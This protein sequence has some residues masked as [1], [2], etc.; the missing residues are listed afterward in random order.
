M[1]RGAILALGLAAGVACAER[2]AATVTIVA[3]Q[4]GAT[5]AGD[6]V[7][8]ELSASGV[9]VVPADGEATA[10]RAHHH[11]FLDIDVTPAG[12]PIPKDTEMQGVKH[13]GTDT[14]TWTFKNVEAGRHRL[15]AVLA[16][17]DHVP[18]EPWTTDTAF[19]TVRSVQP[20][21]KTTP[22]TAGG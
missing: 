22:D 4:D 6:S 5:I 19:F 12:E 15:I 10:G 1:R 17:G 18:L 14:S 20:G 8:V 3:P 21:A 16:R 7:H 9:E 13:L 11:L 2:P